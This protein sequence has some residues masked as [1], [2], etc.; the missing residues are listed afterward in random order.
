MGIVLK[1]NFKNLLADIPRLVLTLCSIAAAF[2]MLTAMG[3][4]LESHMLAIGS[5]NEGIPKMV[6]AVLQP[7]VQTAFALT[8]YVLFEVSLSERKSQFHIMR[9][10]GTTT[11]QLLHGLFAEAMALDAAGAALGIG[12]GYL[13]A[14]LL[15]RSVGVPLHPEVFWGRE[16]FL[17]GVLP[18]FALSPVMML[19]NAPVL[20]REKE[21]K[22][23]KKPKKPRPPFKTRLLPRLFGAGGAL[24]YA[25]GKQQR[26][27]RVLLVAAI[28]VNVVALFLVTAGIAIVSDLYIPMQYDMRI[29][30]FDSVGKDEFYGTDG[31]RLREAL[32]KELTACEKEG[33][34]EEY[35]HFQRYYSGLTVIDDQWLT[36]EALAE[37]DPEANNYTYLYRLNDRQHCSDFSYLYFFDDEM[38]NRYLAENDVPYNGSGGV[39]DNGISYNGRWIKLID[40]LPETA[41]IKLYALPEG[42]YEARQEADD[43][44]T[45]VLPE[46]AWEAVS[47]STDSVYIQPIALQNQRHDSL[48]RRFYDVV[49]GSSIIFPASARGAFDA[50]IEANGRESYDVYYVSAKDTKALYQR[51]SNAIDG[52]YGFY[53]RLQH[54]GDGMDFFSPKNPSEE[55]IVAL[56]TAIEAFDYQSQRNDSQTFQSQMDSLYR[57]FTVMVFLMIALNIVNVVHMNRLSRRREYAILRSLG[58]G[59]RQQL[60]MTLYESFRLTAAAVLWS[61]PSLVLAAWFLYPYLINNGSADN[62]IAR[63]FD[64]MEAVTDTGLWEELALVIKYI[65]QLISPY[66]PLI[67]FAVSFLFFGFVL[68]EHLI[69]RQF[70]KDELVLILKDDIH[71]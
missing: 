13:F 9:T 51:L 28:V 20:L 45:N 24:E 39:I 59:G 64:E 69:D 40:H 55:E 30:F 41:G 3:L 8:L 17:R 42:F 49:T 43:A 7:I 48:Y 2:T 57:F 54:F 33:L 27:H 21:S 67:V 10:A 61:V 36:E 32:E 15:L 14:W 62:M 31:T 37:F 63:I 66:W 16:V 58:L 22:R 50:F 12:L 5:L 38:F 68:A 53:F 46:R 47:K 65:W 35:E 6:S 44:N 71:G 4:S 11:S 1:W 52:K 56:D 29:Q 18:A 70:E 19:L 26:R 34:L 25:L 60:G 23:R